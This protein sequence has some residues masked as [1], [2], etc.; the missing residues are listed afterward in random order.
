M[1]MTSR[2]VHRVPV[3]IA[4]LALMLVLSLFMAPLS[5]H[6]G[7]VTDLDANANW[8][9]HSDRWKDMDLF[10]KLIY[11]FGDLNCHQIM[12]RTLIINGNQMPVCTR[13]VAIFIGVFLGALLLTRAVAHDHPSLVFTSILPKRSRKAKFLMH[14]AVFFTASIILLLTPTALDGGIQTLS[15]MSL[16]PWGMSYE[17][18]NP[19]R[20]LAGFP[21][22]V[23]LG[24]LI[25]SFMVS[26]LSRREDRSGNLITYLVKD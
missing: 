11:T 3:F 21:M 13:D 15:T 6:E 16:L 14:P 23:G 24:I 2:F 8:I 18:T 26:L 25:T 10:P 5:V 17:S 1:V 12:D 7:T 20:I 19:T 4:F 9:D 22:G